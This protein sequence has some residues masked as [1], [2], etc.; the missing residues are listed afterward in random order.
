MSYNDAITMIQR[1]RPQAQPIPEFVTMLQQYEITVRSRHQCG[2]SRQIPL[3]TSTKKMTL[4][5]ARVAND[6][7]AITHDDRKKD[8][9][10]ETLVNAP[11]RPTLQAAKESNGDDKKRPSKNIN[12]IVGPQRPPA[13]SDTITTTIRTE[14]DEQHEHGDE[15]NTKRR[16]PNVMV[17]P[18]RPPPPQLPLP[19]NATVTGTNATATAPD[20]NDGDIKK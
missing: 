17:G 4:T 13:L 5:T 14:S 8:N 20:D 16:K 11:A 15:K 9:D 12:R 10:D 6:I 1:R 19:S 2:G 3:K 7:D 18:Q